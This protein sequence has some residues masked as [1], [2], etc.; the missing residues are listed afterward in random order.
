MTRVLA[1]VGDY[2]HCS[3]GLLGLLYRLAWPAGVELTARRYPDPYAPGELPGFDLV[4]LAAAGQTGRVHAGDCWFTT[5]AQEELAERVRAGSSLLVLHS[6]IAMHPVDGALRRLTGGHFLSHPPDHP[7]V[8]LVPVAD[9]PITRGVEQFGAPDEHYF[10]EVDPDV[11]G[12][13]T[14]ISTHGRQPAGWCREV[15]AGRV[16][17]LTAGHTPAMLE[18]SGLERLWLNAV[19]WCLRAEPAGD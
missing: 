18:S 1:L 11:T 13:L 4:V 6:G 3:D 9:H 16:C 12:L 17:V 8:T 10:L 7:E 14:A 2:Y 19:C 5:G 15:G